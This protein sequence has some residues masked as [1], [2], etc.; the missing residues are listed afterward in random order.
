MAPKAP[1]PPKK[2]GSIFGNQEKIADIDLITDAKA[3]ILVQSP[4]GGRA[5]V[6][7]TLVL[8]LLLIYWASVSEIE[9]VTRGSGKVIPSS[10]IQV[11]QNLEGGIL[12]ESYVHEGDIVKKGQLLMRLDSKRFSAPYEEY[13]SKYLSLLA[14]AARLKSEISGT[15]LV[16]PEEV[17]K[18]HHEIAE[19]E[20]QLHESRENEL[21][22]RVSIRQEQVKQRQQELVELREKL[23]EKTRTYQ[24]L[25]KEL[26]LNRP[27]VENGAVSEVEYL[28][29]QREESSLRGDIATTKVSLP[30][31][32]SALLEARKEIERTRLEFA[33]TIKEEYN[34]VQTQLEG[35]SAAASAL[36]DR[37]DRTSV[38]SPVY[39][40]V[41]EIMVNTIG[42]VI[43][44]GM[45]LMEIVPLEDTLLVEAKIK[46]SDIAFLTPKQRAM[47]KFT[48]YDFTIYGGLEA[49]LEYI[50]ADSSTDDQGNSFYLVRVRTK[51]NYLEDK[52][53]KLPII[54][55]MITIVDIVTGKKTVLSY[56][57]KPIL[58]AQQ[59]ALRER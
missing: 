18:E 37:L 24:F 39:G 43:Q 30:R 7:L 48:A 1:Q 31:A 25:K 55:G 59:M 32:E 56:L 17:L 14:Q 58:R 38:R 22:T 4:K 2:R 27:L 26:E 8:M 36:V 52:H 6:W 54:P 34:D 33:N 49:E 11:V 19:R 21:A 44:P 41:K 42:G 23:T 15:K 28:R 47:V 35:L 53:G 13:R 5:I 40:T 46:P 57:L 3:T 20:K 10:Q 45:N 12:A 51:K 9:E 50:S 16:F 29:L